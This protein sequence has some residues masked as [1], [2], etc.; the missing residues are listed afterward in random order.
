MKKFLATTLAAISA[1]TL[2]VATACGQQ[3]K[4]MDGDAY[5]ITVY[6]GRDSGMTDGDRD[7]AV[8][9]AIE[10]KF[11]R[12]TGTKISLNLQLYTNTDLV[13]TVDVNFNNDREN[14]D[15]IMHYLSEDK[16]SAITKYAKDSQ[17]TIDLDAILS[18]SG[19]QILSKIREN[20]PEHLSDRSGYFYDGEN[21]HRN[22]LTSVAK[23][24]GFGML[25]RK[26]LMREAFNA[27]KID[28]DPEDY[29]ITNDGYKSMTVSEFD[30]VLRAIKGTDA[31][32]TPLNGQPWDLARV[33]ATA[34]GVDGMASFAKDKSGNYVPAQFT[35][36]WPKYVELMYTWARDGIW[37]DESGQTTDDMRVT[38][39]ISGKAAAYCAYPTAEELIKVSKRFY[40]ANPE[41]ELM[42]I[43]PFASEDA[44]GKSLYNADG[45][46]VVNGN[47]KTPR[48]FY[49]MIVPYKSANYRYLIEFLNW[50]YSSA[51][52]YE[53]CLYGVKGVD[54]VD[55]EDFVYGGKTYKTWAYPSGK[56]EEYSVKPPYTGK[57]LLLPNLNVS[58]RISALYNTTEKAWYTSLYFDFPQYGTTELEGIWLQET[59][60]DYATQ[61]ADIEGDYVDNIRSYAW[62]GQMK[63]GKTPVE[64]LKEYVEEK[65]VK[66]AE[67]LSY[68]NTELKRAKAFFNEKYKA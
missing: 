68:I 55:G 23:E 43:A 14:I 30:K 8:K 29:D 16:G 65:K 56:E 12:D 37:E 27:G 18:E 28:L 2:S 20:D 25:M 7:E 53:L 41:A 46:Q 32:M 11:Y 66:D 60:R 6:R 61:L 67:Y 52:N 54:W 26:D 64:I 38:N 36:E 59:P 24:G 15:G 57:Y 62:A 22:A 1:L 13:T 17:A 44:S 51:E 49:G 50:T 63:E 39:L 4:I 19:Q 31:R 48:S 9:Q 3:S 58:N 45:T 5:V 21:Y 10:E 33:V 35:E 47:L 34:Y 40:A 42:V